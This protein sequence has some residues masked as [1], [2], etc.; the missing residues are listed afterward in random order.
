MNSDNTEVVASV[1]KIKEHVERM[2]QDA[3]NFTIQVTNNNNKGIDIEVINKST[4]NVID[5]IKLR[6]KMDSISKP[7]GNSLNGI[8]SLLDS[9][10]TCQLGALGHIFACIFIFG[11]VSYIAIAFYGDYLINYYKL[12]E[13]YPWLVK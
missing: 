9:Y 10:N 3:K 2:N 7:N 6:D 8:F 13:K 12:E 1:G 4:N 11:C 5:E